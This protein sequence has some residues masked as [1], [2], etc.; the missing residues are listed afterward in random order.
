MKTNQ[1]DGFYGGQK[2]HVDKV[3]TINGVVL[4][5]GSTMYDFQGGNLLYCDIGTQFETTGATQIP[6]KSD[7]FID[8]KLEICI[9]S[10][11]KLLGSLNVTGNI[12]NYGTIIGKGKII[13]KIIILPTVDVEKK[14]IYANG[15]PIMITSPGS[16]SRPSLARVEYPSLD[17]DGSWTPLILDTNPNTQ[18]KIMADRRS[19]G[20]RTLHCIQVAVQFPIP[21][22]SEALEVDVGG[23]DEW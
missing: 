11:L 9:G 15:M 2:D 14:R 5:S 22:R 3:H 19:Y 8:G 23:G 1:D 13:G 21:C 18:N 16:A 6:K 20:N 10:Q 12:L 7:I 4:A 17:K